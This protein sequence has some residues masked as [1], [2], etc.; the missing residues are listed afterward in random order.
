[1]PE[2]SQDK[3][4]P[5]YRQSLDIVNLPEGI[6]NSDAS[7]YILIRRHDARNAVICL[8][9]PVK[10]LS[11]LA[12]DLEEN[13][14]ASFPTS[15]TLVIRAK[16][17]PT[18]DVYG[19]TPEARQS[20]VLLDFK[21]SFCFDRGEL[22][23][24]GY[25]VKSIGQTY[26]EEFPHIQIL[27]N[28]MMLKPDAVRQK[29]FSEFMIAATPDRVTVKANSVWNVILKMRSTPVMDVA[30]LLNHLES[31]RIRIQ[32][33]MDT[34][35]V[36]VTEAKEY[37]I[38]ELGRANA[39]YPGDIVFAKEQKLFINALP[40]QIS[41]DGIFT[42]RPLEDGTADPAD[43]PWISLKTVCDLKKISPE[44]YHILTRAGYMSVSEV[45]RDYEDQSIWSEL[46]WESVWSLNEIT[47]A[48]ERI[49][50]V[51]G[52][53]N[54][55]SPSLEMPASEE[56]EIHGVEEI[57]SS[58]ETTQKIDGMIDDTKNKAVIDLSLL[59]AVEQGFFQRKEDATDY[60]AFLSSPKGSFGDR[61]LREIYQLVSS[62]PEA[63]AGHFEWVGPGVSRRL[64]KKII[65]VIEHNP[66]LM[67]V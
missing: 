60:E 30:D 61:P 32:T 40:D 57:S 37:L 65:E 67:P 59:D 44:A 64:T 7:H 25:I 47:K 55:N 66:S 4:S 9:V 54:Q 51:Y 50:T 56:P 28:N 14:A 12:D 62:N 8:A 36:T 63:L 21:N 26:P 27:A 24:A 31:T 6:S 41:N 11:D 46:S 39:S 34:H 43:N 22:I 38:N 18:P 10:S 29:A 19:F 3:T 52:D 42:P 45:L 58:C 5:D 1:M 2:I 15:N 20:F 53:K 16:F 13:K 23:N 49:Y 48:L 35:H 33:I 17:H